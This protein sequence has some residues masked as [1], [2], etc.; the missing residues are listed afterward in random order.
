[1]K[2]GYEELHSLRITSECAIQLMEK[3]FAV[4]MAKQSVIRVLLVLDGCNA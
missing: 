3:R 1:M 2:G 4:S